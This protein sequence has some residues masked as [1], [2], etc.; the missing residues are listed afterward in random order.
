MGFKLCLPPKGLSLKHGLWIQTLTLHQTLSLSTMLTRASFTISML[1]S[2]LWGPSPL[3]IRDWR[4]LGWPMIT[5][6]ETIVSGPDHL[7]LMMMVQEIFSILSNTKSTG[8][9]L[10]ESSSALILQSFRG[11][12][13]LRALLAIKTLRLALIPRRVVLASATIFIFVK[14]KRVLE[15]MELRLLILMKS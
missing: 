6:R 13:M 8:S 2:L 7:I 5:L 12:L 3:E 4:Y 14:A 9:V 15:L 10:V 11:Y 1:V